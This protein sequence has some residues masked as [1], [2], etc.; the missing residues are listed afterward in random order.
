M[1]GLGL[2]YGLRFSSDIRLRQDPELRVSHLHV[3]TTFC[4][5]HTSGVYHSTETALIKVQD[6]I[7]RAIDKKRSVILLLLDLSAVFD[8]VDHGILLDR[9][10]QRFGIVGHA[11]EWFRSYISLIVN[12]S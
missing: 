4:N 5:Q 10:S 3:T 6:D 12:R 9:L 2:D 1:F 11:L 8:T 7:L